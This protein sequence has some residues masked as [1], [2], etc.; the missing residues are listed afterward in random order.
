MLRLTLE[1]KQN[2]KDN[3]E[4]FKM[5]IK[6]TVMTDKGEEEL[7]FFNDQKK[8]VFA[9]PIKGKPT[10]VYLDKDSWILK[11]VKEVKDK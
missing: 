9:H 1:Q 5:P 2:K 8:Q 3:W 4:L 7:T 11:K 6:L 10:K